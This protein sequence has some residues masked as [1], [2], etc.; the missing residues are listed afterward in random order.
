MARDRRLSDRLP[1][2]WLSL[3]R[4]RKCVSPPSTSSTACLEDTRPRSLAKN[5]TTSAIS[6]GAPK[7]AM[8][9]CSVMCRPAL[10]SEIP[11]ASASFRMRIVSRSVRIRPGL[12]ALTRTPSR[13]AAVREAFRQGEHGG[14][15]RAPPM[16]NSA[17]LVLPPMPAMFTT[18][19]DSATSWGQDARQSSTAPNNLMSKPSDQ[20]CSVKFRKYPLL[21]AP[22]LLKTRSMCPKYHRQPQRRRPARRRCGKVRRIEPRLRLRWF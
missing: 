17:P 19:L 9:I 4:Q 3:R 6:A 12:I 22:A 18:L 10:R 2:A 15:D 7:R 1:Q 5:A 20:S 16:V 11:F 21:V 8:L 13:N 14:V